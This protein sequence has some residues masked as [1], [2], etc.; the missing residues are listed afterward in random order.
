VHTTHRASKTHCFKVADEYVPEIS[1]RIRDH[2][3]PLRTA[4]SFACRDASELLMRPSASE[5]R[6][7]RSEMPC[8][9]SPV[10]TLKSGGLAQNV[11]KLFCREDASAART[12]GNLYF[13]VRNR[14]KTRPTVHP[15]TGRHYRR[16]SRA[17]PVFPNNSVPLACPSD[18]AL[19]V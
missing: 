17:S 16:D 19:A 3:K 14:H 1:S 7:S 18:K 8:F 2:A 11:L 13:S 4:P 6:K 10:A 15:S 12:G 5:L 9:L